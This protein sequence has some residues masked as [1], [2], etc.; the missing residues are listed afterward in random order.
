MLANYQW[1][2]DGFRKPTGGVICSAHCIT[3]GAEGCVRWQGK[4]GQLPS[5]RDAAA[6]GENRPRG[7]VRRVFKGRAP[8]F[9]TGAPAHPGQGRAIK[10]QAL[11][12]RLGVVE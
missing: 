9:G 7:A 10:G 6:A 1:T 8:D 2:N 4:S 11:G 5:T 3:A 12:G